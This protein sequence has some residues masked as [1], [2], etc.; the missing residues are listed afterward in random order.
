[1]EQSFRLPSRC[2]AHEPAAVKMLLTLSD[3]LPPDARLGFFG[4]GQYARWLLPLLDLAAL[5]PSIIFD[6]TRPSSQLDGI[7]VRQLTRNRLKQIAA[8]IIASDTFHLSMHLRLLRTLGPNTTA[9]PWIL[10]P[11]LPI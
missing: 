5:R 8:I 2:A 10:N 6:N 3:N 1:M 11:H 7:P 9:S 4:A